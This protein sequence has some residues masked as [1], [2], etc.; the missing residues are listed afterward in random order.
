MVSAGDQPIRFLPVRD[1][2]VL[3]ELENLDRVLALV[4]SLERDP[5]EGVLEMIPAARTVLV[6]FDIE[7]IRPHELAAQISSRNLAQV[8]PV[9]GPLVQ[10]PVRYDGE[11]LAGL[12]ELLGVPVREFVRWHTRTEYKVAFVGFAPGFAYLS[13]DDSRFTVPRLATPRVRVPAGSVALAGNF[14]GIYPKDSPGGWRL[15][16]STPLKMFDPDRNPAA[17][18]QP[19]SR[20]RFI[21]MAHSARHMVIDMSKPA[22]PRRPSVEAAGRL[23]ILSTL[24]PLL[25][26]DGGRAGQSRQGVSISGAAD[27]ASYR[28]ANRLVGNDRGAPALEITLGQV[29]L[30]VHGKTFMAL[31]GA[32]APF[33]VQ[34]KQGTTMNAGRH[35]VVALMDGDVVAI[36]S[37]ASGLRSYL[38]VRGGFESALVLGSASRDV[39]AQIGPLPLVAG[40]Q[41]GILPPPRNAV[42][43]AGEREPFAMPVSGGHVSLDV[44]LGPR[45]DWFTEKSV[46]RFLS[47]EWTVTAESSRTGIRL[48]GQ[49]LERISKAELPS[50]ATVQGAI[51]V[52]LSGQPVLFLTDHP[53]TGGYPVIA[54]VAAHHLDLAGQLP[55]GVKLRFKKLPFPQN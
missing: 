35:E 16:G 29:R 10:I 47:E 11:D 12:A 34:R 36:G 44:T 31:S 55:P 54:N 28:I 6:T 18:L 38:A 50:E 21:D 53:V 4:Y 25:V 45:A 2:S 8:Q 42:V 30:R 5:V 23:E 49:P 24:F 32:P 22:A 7:R 52:P 26:Q 43:S 51:Q 17:L 14:C 3:V 15:I 48:H 41:I 9:D 39:L 13:S 40:A 37:P 1:G 19:G 27:K 20:V 33:T 46:E